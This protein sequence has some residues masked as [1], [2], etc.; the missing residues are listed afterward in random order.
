MNELGEGMSSL[1]TLED[2]TYAF[3]SY[4]QKFDE[5]RLIPFFKPRYVSKGSLP[6]A[7]EMNFSLSDVSKDI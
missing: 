4:I 6:D 7:V 1:Q 5:T 2:I 3:S